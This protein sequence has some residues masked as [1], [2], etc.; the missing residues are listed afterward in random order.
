MAKN[1]LIIGLGG[2][3]G[4]SIAAF[5]KAT[6]L[7]KDDY[8]K[9]RGEGYKFEYLYIDS[10]NDC[11]GADNWEIYGK[12]VKLD[13][14]DIVLLKQTS[15]KT[16]PSIRTISGYENIK[17]WIGDL[18]SS[19][20]KRSSKVNIDDESLDSE[21]FG[22]DGAGQL[23]RYGRVLFAINSQTIRQC[24]QNKLSVLTSGAASEVDVRIFCT[25]GGGTGSGSI[26]DTVTLIQ[27]LAV[28]GHKYKTFVY[29]F[30]AGELRDAQDTGSFYQNEYA[31]LRDLN[32]LM[33]GRGFRPFVV[34]TKNPDSGDSYY[35]S[36]G[37]SPISS[38]Y[39][40]SEESLGTPSLPDQVDFMAKACFDT[41]MYSNSYSNPDCLKALSGEDLVQVNPGEPKGEPRRSYRFAALGAKRLCIPTEQI[42]KLLQQDCAKQV[43]N[44]WLCGTPLLPN[45][46]RDLSKAVIHYSPQ[47]GK[48]WEVI[49]SWVKS[50]KDKLNVEYEGIKQREKR[51]ADTLKGL[52]EKAE[53]VGQDAIKLMGNSDMFAQIAN[54]SEQDAAEILRL[55]Q[56]EMDNRMKWSIGG[57][58][59]W[60]LNDV[61][62]FIEQYSLKIG[63][64]KAALLGSYTPVDIEN[65]RSHLM[66]NMANRETQWEKLGFLTIHLT[67]KDERMIENQYADCCSYA[68]I[69]LF[70]FKSYAIGKLI[71][72]SQKNMT[73]FLNKVRIAIKENESQTVTVDEN[74]KKLSS[75]LYNNSQSQSLCDQYEFD[76]ENLEKVRQKMATLTKE[77]HHNM[78]TVFNQ[79][80]E[81]NVGSLSVFQNNMTNKLM[82]DMN[83]QLREC[84]VELHNRAIDEDSS[85]QNILLGS[86][87]DRLLQ[88]AGETPGDNF[89]NWNKALGEI[90][91][92]FVGEF[93][94]STYVDG[95]GLTDPQASPCKALVFGFPKDAHSNPE[96]ERW[97]KEKLAKSLPD[98]YRTMV[99]RTDF[100]EHET[101]GEIR[102]LYMPYWFPARF[103]P[104]VRGT[105]DKYVASAKNPKDA[106]KIYF[107]NIDDDDIGLQSKKRPALTE[108]GEPDAETMRL[109]DLAS[110]LKLQTPDHIEIPILTVTESGINILL[111]FDNGMPTYSEDYSVDERLYPSYKFKKNLGEGMALAKDMMDGERKEKVLNQYKTKLHE[112][113]SSGANPAGEEVREAK[114]KYE[115]AKVRLGL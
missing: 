89:E 34:A 10:N 47:T 6:V 40:S 67:Q 80:W 110:K 3:G 102:V 85:L 43:L 57:G 35:D 11:L 112:L 26:V 72:E 76:N 33:V 82:Y 23:R 98:Q 22:L 56:I 7:H 103:A 104:V 19:F 13:P 95:K 77:H 48:T 50:V 61:R 49:D 81:K 100:Y 114:D 2:V 75:D 88:I 108:D 29:P 60:G 73:R 44:S 109:V 97:L 92:K 111:R 24:L 63:A 69:A 86:I 93:R 68:D 42:G 36:K 84:S 71:E 9:L 83:E 58:E 91:G 5:R 115:F 21:I 17:P 41:I 52:R 59:A 1:Q 79:A 64:W 106:V 8:E 65:L 101:K 74:I 87:F 99:G 78:A 27:E 62:D 31:A 12:S 107:A 70:D 15:G 55:V 38:I 25:L 46:K 20:A 90:I 18:R 105:Y 51:D 16:A 45:T 96:F 53:Q 113:L 39:L 94:S 14:A 54:S 30:V 4:R 66:D 32:A 37:G 28:G